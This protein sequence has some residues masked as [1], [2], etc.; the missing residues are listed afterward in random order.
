MLNL[1]CGATFHPDW[2]N[3]DFQARG[4]KV[5]GY[6]LELGIP[7]A[8]DSFDVVY[9]SHILEHFSKKRG[10][11]FL[12][13]CFRILRPGGLL[14]VVVPD[15]ENIARA[16]IQALNEAES[17]PGTDSDARQRHEWMLVELI[18]QLT[19]RTSGGEMIK[20]WRKQPVPQQDFIFE[21]LGDEARRWIANNEGKTQTVPDRE[22]ALEPFQPDFLCSGELHRWMYDRISL[23]NILAKLG[24]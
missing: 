7:F 23:K 20:W 3:V 13:E 5:L 21:R 2:I 22:P 11:F 17:A 16:Y 1:G 4:D 9:H 19:R 6:N 18:D 12:K 24:F 14:R 10:E 15:M 8:D